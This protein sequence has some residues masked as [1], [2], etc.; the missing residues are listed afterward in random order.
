MWSYGGAGDPAEIV[1][2]STK[3]IGLNFVGIFENGMVSGKLF[4]GRIY[5][6]SAIDSLSF[7][8]L[9]YTKTIGNG[10]DKDAVSS[11]SEIAKKIVYI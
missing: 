11:E 5:H 1:C 2:I 8:S 3:Q 9:I 6:T 4:K 10:A 7:D